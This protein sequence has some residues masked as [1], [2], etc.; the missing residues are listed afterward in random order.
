MGPLDVLIV[1][2]V[3][4]ALVLCIRRIVRTGGDECADCTSSGTC[5]AH[6]T[7]EGHCPVAGKMVADVDAALS[8]REG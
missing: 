5:S 8:K 7:G 2:V 1:A 4:V 6:L 3:A